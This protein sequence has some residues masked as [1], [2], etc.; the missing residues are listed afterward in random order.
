MKTRILWRTSIAA[1]LLFLVIFGCN[2]DDDP[3]GTEEFQT[4]AFDGQQVMDKLPAGLTNSTDDHAQE[5]VDLIED[6]LDM[7]GFI[8]NMIVP[9]NAVR[10]SKKGSSDTWSWTWSDGTHSYTIY[11]TYSEDNSKHYWT[12]EIQIDGGMRYDFIDAWEYKDNTGGEVVYNFNWT[13]AAYEATDYE[14]LYLVYSWTL[15]SDGDYNFTMTYDSSDPE[16]EY[17]LK[18]EV[19]VMDDGSGTIDYWLADML[20]YQ[21]EWTAAGAGSWIYYLGGEQSMSGTWGPA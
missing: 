7:S 18:Y 12:E 21:F 4:L 2:K 16:F 9:D 1:L 15:N 17:Y 20:L 14:D 8:D 13:M 11:W 19:V 10:S 3:P 6:A 5:C